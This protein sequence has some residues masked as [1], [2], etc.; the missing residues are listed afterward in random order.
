MGEPAA[1]KSHWLL[2]VAYQIAQ[3]GKT[4]I[5]QDYEEGRD[6]WLLHLNRVRHGS[7][8]RVSLGSWEKDG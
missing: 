3:S 4:V 6:D 1:G 5:W 8:E 7:T 2:W